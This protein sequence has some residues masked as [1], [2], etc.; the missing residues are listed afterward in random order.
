MFYWLYFIGRAS[1]S[2]G[3]ACLQVHAWENDKAAAIA[4]GV[5]KGGVARLTLRAVHLPPLVAAEEL[6]G[7][8]EP[9][10]ATW[11]LRIGAEELRRF[12]HLLLTGAS[13]PRPPPFPFAP[14]ASRL[15]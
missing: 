6:A 9:P 15:H 12:R 11:A 1:H 8:L 2:E 7:R 5:S 13:P 4:G 3:S 10:P 14:Y